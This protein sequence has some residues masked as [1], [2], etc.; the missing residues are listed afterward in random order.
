MNFQ[1]RKLANE[2]AA[3]PLILVATVIDNNP[4][5]VARAFS[6]FTGE[7]VN[8]N[9]PDGMLE[10]YGEVLRM[11]PADAHQLAVQIL[12]VPIIPANL[13]PIAQ[14]YVLEKLV[15]AEIRTTRSG[16]Y[17]TSIDDLN[18]EVLA[19]GS[20]N[21]ADTGG[22]NGTNWGS[23]V[24]TLIPGI[25]SSFGITSNQNVNS[26]LPPQQQQSTVN[27]TMIIIVLVILVIA[28][29]IIYKVAK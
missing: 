4:E 28:A 25:L 26:P 12:D 14:D 19:S 27:W 22:S 7:I 20:G 13:N 1:T 6:A 5:A 8:P 17:D 10:T 3:N 15:D 9:D 16:I 21:T 18:Q 23:V 2:I 29:I 11:Y 24:S